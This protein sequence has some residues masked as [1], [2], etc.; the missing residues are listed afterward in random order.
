MYVFVRIDA[1]ECVCI[2]VLVL[3]LFDELEHK[4]IFFSSTEE[5]E[6]ERLTL[7]C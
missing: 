2:V 4:Y 3:Q 6:I 5:T 7:K 1:Y